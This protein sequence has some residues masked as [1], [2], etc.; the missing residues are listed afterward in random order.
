[1]LDIGC[2]NGEFLRTMVNMGAACELVG[3]ETGEAGCRAAQRIG[4]DV[5]CTDLPEAGFPDAHFDLV[6]MWGVL[7]HVHDPLA[8]LREVRRVL[9]PD[10]QVAIIVPNF[11]C[12]ERRMFGARWYHVAVP[13]HLFHFD[14]TT[15][16]RLLTAA[17]FEG[18]RIDPIYGGT[19]REGSA[20]YL[21]D[22]PHA[23]ILTKILRRAG[24]PLW[25]LSDLTSRGEFI[26]ATAST[27]GANHPK[28]AH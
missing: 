27:S 1:L 7:E 23:P 24:W 19:A 22:N 10:G 26:R 9:R 21:R 4:L 16:R 20:L 17:G 15:L 5:R 6:T 25:V 8:T 14:P 11:A 28:G 2:G 13:W 18:I 3:I 12:R